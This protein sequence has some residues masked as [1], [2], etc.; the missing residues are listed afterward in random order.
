MRSVLLSPETK[1]LIARVYLQNPKQKAPQ[2][3]L[4]VWQDT[5][6]ENPALPKKW[7]SLSSIQKELAR[8]RREMN[9]PS[10]EEM[11]WTLDTLRDNPLSPEVLPKVFQIWLTNQEN[12]F[13]PPLSIREA[14][15]IA[16]LSSMTED[17]ERLRAV[18]EVCAEYELIGELTNTPQ[19]SSP[20]TML[21]YYSLLTYMQPGE[22]KEHHEAILKEK[23]PSVSGPR[24]ERVI[25]E[26]EAIYGKS[27][28]KT[29]KPK[30]KS[31]E[32]GTK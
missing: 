6:K 28:L 29:V 8:I 25:A 24:H 2:V 9:E 30:S 19:L 5:H 4:K 18:A 12:P 1:A 14:R 16:Q 23:D 13:S 26:L 7:P 17:V 3:R 15:W 21:H 10:P 32:G 20:P 11:P 22:E 27:V 31:K